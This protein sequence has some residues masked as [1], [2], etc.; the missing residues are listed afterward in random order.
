MDFDDEYSLG[1]DEDWEL[2]KQKEENLGNLQANETDGKVTEMFL[3]QLKLED[4]KSKARDQKEQQGLL[5]NCIIY[6]KVLIFRI[7]IY[8][9]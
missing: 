7:R 1:T 6:F 3:D 2:L 5:Y 8:F 9:R 4:T